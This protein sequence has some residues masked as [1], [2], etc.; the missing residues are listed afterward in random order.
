MRRQSVPVQ[1]T[2]CILDDSSGQEASTRGTA[3]V[4][5]LDGSS[6]KAAWMSAVEQLWP[7]MFG[8]GRHWFNFPLCQ[9]E[10]RQVPGDSGEPLRRASQFSGRGAAAYS[11]LC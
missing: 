9:L 5:P 4:F 7:C 2:G 11:K 10:P 3:R 8:G 6:P 1:W